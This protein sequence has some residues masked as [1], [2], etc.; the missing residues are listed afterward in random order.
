MIT[1]RLTVTLSLFLL[2]GNKI[3]TDVVASLVET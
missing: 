1:L 2:E 3:A